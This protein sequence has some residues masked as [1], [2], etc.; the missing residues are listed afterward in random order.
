M[1]LWS[2]SFFAN[3]EVQIHFDESEYEDNAIF[4]MKKKA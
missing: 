2:I 1:K 4:K 3:F